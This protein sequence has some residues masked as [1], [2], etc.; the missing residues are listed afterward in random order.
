MRN[1]SICGKPINLQPPASVRAARDV[2]GKSAAYYTSLFTTHSDCELKKRA[3]DTAEMMRKARE[4]F[5][6][7]WSAGH[8]PFT[9][10]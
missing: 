3:E 5:D 9:H 1:C 2:T 4:R 6:E 7:L 8:Y 10:P